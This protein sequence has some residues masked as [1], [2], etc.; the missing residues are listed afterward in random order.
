MAPPAPMPRRSEATVPDVAGLPVALASGRLRADGFVAPDGETDWL[1]VAAQVPAAGV[2]ADVGS[3]VDLEARDAP[4]AG[5][6][7][8]DLRGL[9]ARQAIAWLASMGARARVVGSGAVAAQSVA[10]GA[11][12][13]DEITLTLR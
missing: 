12:L 4:A 7:A 9:G 2:R 3:A 8:P 13:P 1:R 6:S 11:A 10:P 5:R